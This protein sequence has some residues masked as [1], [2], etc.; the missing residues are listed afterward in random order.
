[1]SRPP[2]LLVIAPGAFA[3]TILIYSVITKTLY[4]DLHDPTLLWVLA[5]CLCGVWL[6]RHAM[7]ER[8]AA[9]FELLL[10]TLC[11]LTPLAMMFTWVVSDQIVWS[12]TYGFCGV[13][14]YM[15]T[16]PKDG[17]PVHPTALSAVIGVI[18]VSIAPVGLCL[19]RCLS[20]EPV[21]WVL[22][23]GPGLALALYAVLFWRLD[24]YLF[25]AVMDGSPWTVVIGPAWRALGMTAMTLLALQ[26]T[27]G[28]LLGFGGASRLKRK[29]P[30]AV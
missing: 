28:S 11:A 26:L 2:L 22:L 23:L 18:T 9:W 20:R 24:R 10:I 7:K 12:Q 6:A 30:A 14:D 5:G 1:M 8:R 27:G 4:Y 29:T 25:V 13:W 16:H 3:L 15:M 21:P 17:W 19:Y